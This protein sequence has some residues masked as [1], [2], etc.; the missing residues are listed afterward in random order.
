MFIADTLNDERVRKVNSQG[1]ITTVAANL[2]PTDLAIDHAGNVFIVDQHSS[3]IRMMNANGDVITIA[4]ISTEGWG[5][6]SGD[7]GPAALA[8]L[9]FP[10][11]LALGAQGHCIYVADSSNSRVSVAFSLPSTQ[12]TRLLQRFRPD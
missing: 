4:G 5:G 7:G 10:R 3:R 9:N 1:I 6:F 8:T 11:S 12:V 2:M